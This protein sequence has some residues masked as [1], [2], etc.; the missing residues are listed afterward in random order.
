M[1]AL[2]RNPKFA[3]CF[4]AFICMV[5]YLAGIYTR[6]LFPV[7]ETRYLGVAWEMYASKNFLVPH[8]NFQPY[9]HKPPLLFWCINI[10]WAL[11]GVSQEVA[12]A[13]PLISAFILVACTQRL[14]GKLLPER[15]ELI[16]YTTYILVGFLPF[17]IYS[18]MV[19]FDILLAIFVVTGLTCIWEYT[20]SGSKF[21]LRLLTLSA[22]LGLLT[23]GPVI[24]LHL[25]APVLLARFWNNHNNVPARIWRTHISLSCLFALVIG[26]SWAVPASIY[27]GADFSDRIFWGQTAGRVANAFDHKQ[28]FWWYLPFL[29]LL[30][31]P[32]ILSPLVWK[33]LKNLPGQE[34]KQA[35]RFLASWLLPVFI[36]FC[37]ISGKQIHYLLPLLPGL[38]I[39]LAIALGNT[40]KEY[41]SRFSFLPY[42]TIA[43]FLSLP[44][45]AKFLGIAPLPA[46][47]LGAISYAWGLVGL[48]LVLALFW[49]GRRNR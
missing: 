29:P 36:S 18:N 5:L 34:Y 8:L 22:G 28:A 7:D 12:M 44:L 26:L 47:I 10:L 20:K 25:L 43:F 31:C 48:L 21:S 6:P 37:F 4:S 23:K 42:A 32:W 16:A 49:L 40:D 2:V 35:L 30:L 39:I 11:F 45:A 9:D 46:D 41:S 19:M 3:L 24:F 13:L 17:V 15:P 1:I 14:A 33:N 27:G 38:A